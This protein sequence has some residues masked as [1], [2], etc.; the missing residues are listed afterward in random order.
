MNRGTAGKIVGFRARMS[1]S[2]SN[3]ETCKGRRNKKPNSCGHVRKRGC[4]VN[5]LS[6]TK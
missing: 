1:Y 2:I 6:A 3:K 5:L 4:G